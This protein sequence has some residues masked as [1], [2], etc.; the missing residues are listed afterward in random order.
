[1]MLMLLLTELA[2]LEVH[3]SVASDGLHIQAPV[4]TLT[5]ELCQAMTEHKAALVRYASIP[6]V[7]ADD[8]GI[9]TGNQLEQDIT[10]VAPQRQEAWHYK[11][12]V[13]S[14]RDGVERFYW[15]R[16]VLQARPVDMTNSEGIPP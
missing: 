16:I 6:Y 2:R 8:V 4:G 15:P 14:L 9:L 10:F 7:I 13:R 3:L 1:M 5:D 12:G 11:I